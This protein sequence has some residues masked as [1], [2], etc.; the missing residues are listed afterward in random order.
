MSASQKLFLMVDEPHSYAQ[1][2]SGPDAFAAVEGHYTTLD[3]WCSPSPDAD[4][5]EEFLLFLY[6]V[7]AHLADDLSERFEDLD[8]DE[9]ANQVSVFTRENPS[10]APVEV[11]VTYTAVEGAKASK[12]PAFPDLFSGRR[13]D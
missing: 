6:E 12:L 9:L 13:E 3:A 2:V 8:G 4:I 5:S 1:L 10:V 11:N 7:P